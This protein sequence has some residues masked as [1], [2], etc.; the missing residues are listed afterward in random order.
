[1]IQPLISPGPFPLLLRTPA[2]LSFWF[3]KNPSVM[4]ETQEMRVWSLDS[5]DPLEKDMAT[6]SSAWK[7]PWTEGPGRLQSKGLQ[8]VRHYWATKHTHTHT[9]TLSVTPTVVPCTSSFYVLKC[10]ILSDAPTH[11]KQE[12]GNISAALNHLFLGLLAWWGGLGSSGRK[13]CLW[14]KAFIFYGA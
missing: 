9:H 10:T 2:I 3:P 6:H 14:I 8:R 5:E 4:Q 13:Y 12:A 1:M 7:I 11:L